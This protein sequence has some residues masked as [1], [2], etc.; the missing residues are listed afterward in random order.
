MA[1]ESVFDKPYVDERDKNNLE[2]LL[3]QLNLPPA[4]V[5]FVRQN[6]K[7]VQ[8]VSVL[9]V[10]A[11][12]T[13]ALYGSYREKK[14]E[15]STT[16]L[17]AALQINGEEK[18]AALST[19]EK[20]Y[21]GTSSALWAKI[22]RAHELSSQGKR[23][24]AR[25]IYVEVKDEVGKDSSLIPLLDLAI[26]QIDEALGNFD[27]ALA[28]YSKVKDEEGYQELG[29]LGIGRIHELKKDYAKALE[30]YQ[31]YLDG[32]SSGQNAS[33]KALVEAKITSIKAKL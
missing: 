16:A 10:V 33:Q 21:S 1:K 6:K 14:I 13:W 30:V 17:S 18:I 4:V 15:E 7:A 3:E 5:R 31:E 26:A 2:G 24:D 28:E 22:N 25:T 12:V 8:I 29:Y 19:V 32:A 11:V 27:A 23:E 20:N 9:V